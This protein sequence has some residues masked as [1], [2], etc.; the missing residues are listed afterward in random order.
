MKH[1]SFFKQKAQK[2]LS[3]NDYLRTDTN[4]P[5]MFIST[6]KKAQKYENTLLVDL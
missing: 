2:R 3:E 4:V 5:H 6:F 1:R